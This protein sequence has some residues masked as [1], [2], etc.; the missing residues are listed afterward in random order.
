MVGLWCYKGLTKPDAERCIDL[1]ASY[2]K[3]FVDLM[4]TEEL[5]MFA[6]PSDAG[7]RRIT[8]ALL[9]AMG[10]ACRSCCSGACWI[11]STAPCWLARGRRVPTSPRARVGDAGAGFTGAWR[12][13]TSRL[14]EQRRA[15]E[16]AMLG[17]AC[18]VVPG[19]SSRRAPP[20]CA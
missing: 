3:F 13:S 12:A 6:P 11:T 14:P 8:G 19:S 15:L 10:G 1:L 9:V 18:H 20:F 16:A 5:R 17:A 7:Y 2:K 4:M